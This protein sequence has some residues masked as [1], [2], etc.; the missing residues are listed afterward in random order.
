LMVISSH[1]MTGKHVWLS[2]F[3]NAV[4]LAI[5][6]HWKLTMENS[7]ARTVPTILTNAQL[8]TA[9]EQPAHPRM[10]STCPIIPCYG[11]QTAPPQP[12]VI[13]LR[14]QD[15]QAIRRTVIKSIALL[16]MPMDLLLLQ[17][18]MVESR[19]MGEMERLL[20]ILNVG[21]PVASLTP[22]TP[23]QFRPLRE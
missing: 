12:T 5:R 3:R 17:V 4:S 20:S 9:A 21:S 11:N 15:L 14:N 6:L 22:S 8:P 1:V 19:V 2:M 13:G 16:N 18:S 10:R 23:N 7:G